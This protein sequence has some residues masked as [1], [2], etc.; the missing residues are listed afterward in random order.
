MCLSAAP[1]CSWKGE[2]CQLKVHYENGFT[3]TELPKLDS[4]KP[5]ILWS[6]SYTQLRTS[7]DDGVQ[8]L[9][10]DF[11]TEDGEKVRNGMSSL[12]KICFVPVVEP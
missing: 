12:R 7:A 3:L 9:W 6:H 10:L 4:D 1:E 11:G 2:P 5:Q 8:L